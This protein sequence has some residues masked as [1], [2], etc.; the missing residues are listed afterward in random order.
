M[1]KTVTVA[2]AGLAGCEAAWQIAKQGIRVKLIDMKPDKMTEVH[3]YSGLSELVCSNSFKAKKIENASG[4]LKKELDIMGSLIMK[5]AIETSIPAG[6]ALAV[7]REG[8]S[9]YITKKI[10]GNQYIEYI[11][12][13]VFEIPDDE[14]FIIAT[15]P[16]TSQKMQTAILKLTGTEHLNFFDAASPIITKDSIDFN[17]AFYADRYGRGSDDYINCP[18]SKEQYQ[19]FHNELVNAERVIIKEHEKKVFEGCMPVEVMAGRGF[20]TL[21]YGPLKPVGIRNPETGQEYY[22]IVQLRRDNKENTLYNI[23]GFQT[24]LKFSEQ[25]RVFSLIPALKNAEY[26]RYGVMHKNTFINS[27]KLLGNTYKLKNS[28]NIFFAGQITGVEGYME[29]TSS[30]LVAGINAAMEVMGKEKIIFPDKTAIGALANYISNKSII[31]FQPM[32]INFGIINQDDIKKV[33]KR[34]RKLFIAEKSISEVKSIN[35]KLNN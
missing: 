16:L 12:K 26:L 20:D 31:N 34:E 25:K 33:K 27:P 5:A 32:N 15:G 6:G 2:G 35:N 1:I 13:E 7:D 19:D 10:M 4:L 3:T 9:D 29:S 14:L 11:S 28:E 22:A 18:L 30:G 24:N 23:V 17:E 8:F 21:R